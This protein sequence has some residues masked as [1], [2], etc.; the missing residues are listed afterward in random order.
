[1]LAHDSNAFTEG[2]DVVGGVIYESTGRVGTSYLQLSDLETLEPGRR[3]DLDPHLF[4]EGIGVAAGKL[5]QITWQDGIAIERDP[6]TLAEMRR[7]RYDGEGWGLCGRGDRLVMSDG[8]ATLTFRDPNTFEATG[9]IE[10]TDFHD[11]RLNELDCAD[12]GFVYANNWP[13]STILRIDPGTGHVTG[14]IDA[15]GLLDNVEITDEQLNS[16][17]VLNGIAHL[18]GTDRFLLTGKYWPVLFEVRFVQ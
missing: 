7:V 6:T 2:L 15:R 4:G 16:L 18:P 14:K 5:W 12:D 8:S 1:V 17:D 3:V 13:T 11:A 10:L 9:S